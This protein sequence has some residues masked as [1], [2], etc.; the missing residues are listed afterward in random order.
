MQ[1]YVYV[2]WREPILKKGALQARC[3]GPRY[4]AAS[5]RKAEVFIFG[6]L[7][8]NGYKGVIKYRTA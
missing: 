6:E 1:E 3:F 8:H 4:C 2:Y 7:A 5:V